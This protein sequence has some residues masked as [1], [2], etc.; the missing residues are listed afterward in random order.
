M[1]QSKCF[2]IYIFVH[3][4]IQNIIRIKALHFPIFSSLKKKKYTGHDFFPCFCTWIAFSQAWCFCMYSTEIL[5]CCSVQLPLFQCMMMHRV[6]DTCRIFTKYLE[7]SSF[8]NKKK[9]S[10]SEFMCG[11]WKQVD[12]LRAV[13]WPMKLHKNYT[14]VSWQS[15]SSMQHNS[16]SDY[17]VCDL[18]RWLGITFW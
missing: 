11:R 5:V 16:E 2:N 14:T 18:R 3:F 7:M 4:F 17:N 10:I 8:D 9:I 12:W 1:S 6:M 13:R 15:Q